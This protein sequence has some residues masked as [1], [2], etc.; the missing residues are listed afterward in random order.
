MFEPPCSITDT[1][2]KEL[3]DELTP[4][5]VGAAEDQLDVAHSHHSNLPPSQREIIRVSLKLNFGNQ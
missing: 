4:G 5:C 2:V 1:S 3:R